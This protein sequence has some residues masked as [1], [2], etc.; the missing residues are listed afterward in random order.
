M[1]ITLKSFLYAPLTELRY[2]GNKIQNV[3]RNI[4]YYWP[5]ILNDTDWDP[6]PQL[7]LLKVKLS[8]QA[9]AFRTGG[10]SVPAPTHAEQMEFCDKLIDRILSDPYHD[11]AFFNYYKKWGKPSYHMSRNETGGFSLLNSCSPLVKTEKDQLLERKEYIEACMNAD[12]LKKQDI[13]Y[14]YNY[15]AKHI[16]TWWD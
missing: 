12:Y 6:E 4:K 1:R 14:L 2:I 3:I 7:S 8:K 13:Q 11:L 15:M 16:L 9:E 5:I 10:I